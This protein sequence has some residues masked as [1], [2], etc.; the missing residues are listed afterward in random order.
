MGGYGIHIAQV[1]LYNMQLRVYDFL[2]VQLVKQ[3]ENLKGKK[4]R[5]KRNKINKKIA[6]I[7]EVLD[8]FADI[9]EPEPMTVE[10][11]GNKANRM[12]YKLME[13]EYSI[14]KMGVI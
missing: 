1:M 4:N 7:A 14:P 6:C 2:G 10:V 3:K 9:W 5:H 11:D 8:T 13:R 12:F